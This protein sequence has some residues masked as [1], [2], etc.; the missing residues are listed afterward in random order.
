MVKRC[1]KSH[2]LLEMT[3][4]HQLFSLSEKVPRQISAQVDCAPASVGANS[5]FRLGLCQ[6]PMGSYMEN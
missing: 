3:A 5:D 6:L 4:I 1:F 2:H